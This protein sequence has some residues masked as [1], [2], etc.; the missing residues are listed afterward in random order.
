MRSLMILHPLRF[1][2]AHRRGPLFTQGSED[3]GQHYFRYLRSRPETPISMPF[4]FREPCRD[5]HMCDFPYS[6]SRFS[7]YTEQGLAGSLSHPCCT[8][9][10]SCVS[11][12]RPFPHSNQSGYQYLR[13]PTVSCCS[14]GPLWVYFDPLRPVSSSWLASRATRP[15]HPVC[16]TGPRLFSR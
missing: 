13:P 5:S 9:F 14:I 10:A 11:I 4:S 12:L 3:S 15:A 8:Y 2:N 6:S 7:R 1:H 16:R